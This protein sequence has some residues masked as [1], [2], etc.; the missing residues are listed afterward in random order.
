MIRTRKSLLDAANVALVPLRPLSIGEILDGAFLMLRRSPRPLL[1]L[2]MAVTGG[3]AVI[4]TV[5]VALTSLFLDS[6]TDTFAQF[7]VVAGLTL[8]GGAIAAA[9]FFWTSGLLM[10][11]SL[12]AVMG[13]EFAPPKKLTV[14]EAMRWLGPMLAMVLLMSVAI[15][16]AQW[17][18][19]IVSSVLLVVFA[20]FPPS[21][22]ITA[23]LSIGGILLG[24]LF[25]SCWTLSWF[26]LAL[27]VYA[28]EG[29]LAATWVGKGRR[30]TNVAMAFVRSAR[31]VG[32]R[33]SFR[34]ALAHFG[35][36]ALLCLAALF[37]LFGSYAVTA[38]FSFGIGDGGWILTSV[39]PFVF[40]AALV[41]IAAIGISYLSALQTLLYLDLRMRREGLD[42]ALRFPVVPVPEPG[43]GG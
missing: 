22:S 21:D 32:W 38:L 3:F 20:A 10:R 35:L 33:D 7:F 16:A 42:L 6:F 15:G 36:V 41:L 13:Q 8:V 37:A 18:A 17:A 27:P 24:V 19:S 12:M 4:T 39:F 26:S 14:R 25:V 28:A 34:V 2:S 29:P 43:T 5:N 23:F 30:P 40:G 31:L 9:V 11:A 1:G